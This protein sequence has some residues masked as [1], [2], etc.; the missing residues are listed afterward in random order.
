MPDDPRAWERSMVAR[1]TAG[2]DSALAAVYDQ[3]APLVHGI[4]VRLVGSATAADV[5]QE[6]FVA[7]W[8]HPER[9]DVERGTLR[10]YLATIA[11]CRS[12]D[13]LR[14]TG[15]RA[16]NEQRSIQHAATT[17]PN[18]EEA[19]LAMIAAERLRAAVERL[20]AEQRRAIEL[21]YFGGLT[22]QQVAQATG[23][24]EGTAKSRLRLA[25]EHLT[26]ALRTDGAVEWA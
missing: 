21:A 24:P 6:V 11:R 18:V 20:P 3:Y 14:R 7:L 26:R 25:L 10:T 5:C 12:I 17:A 16:A 2:D 8:E 1:I 19:A 22:F 15:R 4:A 23:A 13:V 9:F